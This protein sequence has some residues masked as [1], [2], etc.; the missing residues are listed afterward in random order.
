MFILILYINHSFN[1]LAS[2]LQQRAHGGHVIAMT[3]PRSE[4]VKMATAG[5]LQHFC[6]ISASLAVILGLLGLPS[7]AKSDEQVPLVLWTSEG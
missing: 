3:S 7:L 4:L 5:T 6:R 2:T 1:G